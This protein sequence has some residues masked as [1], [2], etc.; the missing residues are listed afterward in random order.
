MHAL[1]TET[2]GWKQ[3]DLLTAGGAT[4]SV[5]PAIYASTYPSQAY[6]DDGSITDE[7][8]TLPS[9]LKEMGFAT[10]GFC[11]SNPFLGKWSGE[12]DNFWNDSLISD[13]E[14]VNGTESALSKTWRFLTFE[15]RIPDTDVLIKAHNWWNSTSGRKFMHVHL[16]GP[17]APYYPGIGRASRIGPLR[18]YLAILGYAKRREDLPAFVRRHVK[19]LYDQCIACLDEVLGEFLNEFPDDPLIVLTADHGEE[20]DHGR[21]GHARLY[22]ETTRCPYLTNDMALVP[23]SS[24]IRQIDLAPTILRRVDVSVPDSWEGQQATYDRTP[25]QPMWNKGTRRGYEWFGVHDERRKLIE[26]LD[27]DGQLLNTE[28]YQLNNDPQEKTPVEVVSGVQEMEQTL[29][30]FKSRFLEGNTGFNNAGLDSEVDERLRE[31]GYK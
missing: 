21:F 18:S 10:A 7:L 30:Q 11:A 16:M 26:M 15:Q 8:T 20:F 25:L 13:S 24:A 23:S 3:R 28:L 27:S 29:S 2:T 17:H 14:C 4:N 6:E 19:D 22:N 5:F 1:K 31:L 9:R 12:F